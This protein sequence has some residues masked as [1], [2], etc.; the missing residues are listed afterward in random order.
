MIAA[1]QVCDGRLLGSFVQ[2]YGTVASSNPDEW[3]VLLRYATI[4]P[5]PSTEDSTAARVWAT[6]TV[7]Q[8]TLSRY[9]RFYTV[10]NDTGDVSAH[11]LLSTGEQPVAPNAT[12]YTFMATLRAP[13]V[14]PPLVR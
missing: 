13:D 12:G 8:P 10:N 1:G 4:I 7:S 9:V 3:K 11:A 2:A 14:L 6:L 5:A